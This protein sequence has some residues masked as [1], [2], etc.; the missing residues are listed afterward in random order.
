VFLSGFQQFAA[1]SAYAGTVGEAVIGDAP[2][3]PGRVPIGP[4]SI[5]IDA[6]AST[7]VVSDLD[8]GVDGTTSVFVGDAV[9]AGVSFFAGPYQYRGSG[10]P[11]AGTFTIAAAKGRGEVPFVSGQRIPYRIAG[12]DST[13]RLT[14][15]ASGIT[16]VVA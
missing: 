10:T 4:V 9:S 5:V 14:T 13:G 16:T 11:A 1:T 2:T 3:T 8:A 15:V 7:I 6:S 12:Y